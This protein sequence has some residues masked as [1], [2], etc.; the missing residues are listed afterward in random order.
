[1]AGISAADM[2]AETEKLLAD[3]GQVAVSTG[4]SKPAAPP[5]PPVRT[6]ASSSVVI[7]YKA[8]K[9][10]QTDGQSTPQPRT[11]LLYTS[12]SPRDRQ[13]SRMPSS[14]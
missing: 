9:R 14:A 1:M 12:P 8:K 13:K 4:P 2:Q 10:E 6:D 11:C 3:L 5:P 7:Q